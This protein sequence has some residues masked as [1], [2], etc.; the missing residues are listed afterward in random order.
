[1]EERGLVLVEDKLREMGHVIDANMKTIEAKAH[2]LA[3][4]SFQLTS[5]VQLRQ[6]LYQ[7][8]KLDRKQTTTKTGL[9]K[10]T[11]E[12]T[13][14]LLAKLHPLPDLII[15]H[16]QLHKMKTTYVDGILTHSKKG[17]HDLDEF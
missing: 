17:K 13:L 4:R 9:N 15:Q 11:S 2:K 12:S 6:I 10:S 1:M 16:R 3:G 7:E 8:L 14:K 5:H